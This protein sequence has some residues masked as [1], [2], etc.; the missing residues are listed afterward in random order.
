MRIN[1]AEKR[2]H[3]ERVG[4]EAGRLAHGPGRR[5]WGGLTRPP[6]ARRRRLCGPGRAPGSGGPGA[7]AAP[8][9]GQNAKSGAQVN[10]HAEQAVG[11][12]RAHFGQNAKPE[13]A[14]KPQPAQVM[15][16]PPTLAPAGRR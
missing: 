7:R 10:P 12:R 2:K 16:W 1:L 4:L 15:L 13:D 3:H 14:T 11:S 8:Q 9:R 6:L 5:P